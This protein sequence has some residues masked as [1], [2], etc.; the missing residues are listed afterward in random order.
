MKAQR[1]AHVQGYF[2]G[3]GPHG[4]LEIGDVRKARSG[5]D[6]RQKGTSFNANTTGICALSSPS[7]QPCEAFVSCGE[8]ELADASFLLVFHVP[9]LPAHYSQETKKHEGRFNRFA[10]LFPSSATPILFREPRQSRSDLLPI[11]NAATSLRWT[12]TL[13]F[14]DVYTYGPCSHLAGIFLTYD[15]DTTH[16]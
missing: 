10:C 6:C 14:H 12:W 16:R 2:S 13:I 8:R 5:R 9:L 3:A 15:T 7:F 4:Q 11:D 1:P